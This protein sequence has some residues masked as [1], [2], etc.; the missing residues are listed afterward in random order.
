MLPEADIVWAPGLGNRRVPRSLF[1]A[2]PRGIATI[3]GLNGLDA[4]PEFRTLGLRSGLG[5]Y[6]WRRRIRGDWARLGPQVG[7]AILVSRV[8][9]A[10]ASGLLR[11]PE[12]RMQ[13]IPHGVSGDFFRPPGNPP[14]RYVL[15]VSQYSSVKNIPRILAAYDRVRDRIGLPLRIVSGGW[16]GDP[17]TLPPGVEMTTAL[18]PHAAV[19]DLMWGARVFLFPSIEDAFGLPVLE[20]MAAGVPVVTS[21]GTGAG[22]VAGDAGL[23]VD[24]A[25]TDAIAAALL[26]AATDMALH[27]RLARAGRERAMTFSWDAAADRH[28]ALMLRVAGRDGGRDDGRDGSRDDG[29]DCVRDR[30]AA[31]AAG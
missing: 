17:A 24:P 15:H 12:G 2:G 19:R 6:L 16:P 29:G 23:C 10:R 7:A 9:A 13:V 4:A 8:L 28:L 1:A 3:H 27:D 22:E 11:I 21:A 25:D 31:G 5:H 18:V 30:E 20:A 14:G 26:A